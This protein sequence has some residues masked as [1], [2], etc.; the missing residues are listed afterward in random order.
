MRVATSAQLIALHLSEVGLRRAQ[1]R[2]SDLVDRRVLARLPRTIGGHGA[3][4]SGH[5]YALDVAWQRLA[6][7]A[8]G[9]RVR[10]PW[11]LGAGFLAHS[12]AVTEVY[13][14]LVLAERTGSLRVVRFVAEAAS[15]RGFFGPGGARVVLKPDSYAV[16]SVDGWEDYWFLE[17][18]LD[19]EHAPTIARKCAVYRDYCRS[20][21][22]QARHEVFPRVLWLVPDEHRAGVLRRVLDRLPSGAKELFDVALLDAVVERMLQ[23]AAP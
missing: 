20:G 3:G 21:T 5:V 16:V 14:R 19:T 15:W 17:V 13:V 1:R 10:R 9:G 12:L 8:D 4:S 7:L 18:D 22:E 2:L 6:D 23:G 11:A